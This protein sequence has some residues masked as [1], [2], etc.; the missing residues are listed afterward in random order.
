MIVVDNAVRK[1][2]VID[3]ESER[4]D[5]KGMRRFFDL[6][7]SDNRVSAT[8]IQTVG[9]KGYDGFVIAVVAGDPS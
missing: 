8:A 1:G 6:A 4:E 3:A 5:V 2:A 9:L 7:S